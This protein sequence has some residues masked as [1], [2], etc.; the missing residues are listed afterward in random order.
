M[1]LFPGGNVAAKVIRLLF[2]PEPAVLA[3]AAPPGATGRIRLAESPSL[4]ASFWKPPPRSG[5]DRPGPRPLEARLA[6][7]NHGGRGGTGSPV[8]EGR[9]GP[10][11]GPPR[12]PGPRPRRCGSRSAGCLD[13]RRGWPPDRDTA[14]RASSHRKPPW[15]ALGR[16]P[17]LRRL[18]AAFQRRRHQRLDTTSNPGAGAALDWP[19]NTA[20]GRMRPERS[21]RNSSEG[22]RLPSARH[23]SFSK[24]T[25][26][27]SVGARTCF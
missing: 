3:S 2:K 9:E 22:G 18:A 8:K 20:R 26:I 10:P 1:A 27:S 23:R 11:Q 24:N 25:P 5:P 14:Q 12:P 19:A 15:P 7:K 16:I 4:A 6:V 13:R 21:A 17:I